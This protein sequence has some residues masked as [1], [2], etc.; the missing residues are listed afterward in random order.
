M[1]TAVKLSPATAPPRQGLGKKPATRRQAPAN[2]LAG[3]KV[4]WAPTA[5][6]AGRAAPASAGRACGLLPAWLLLRLLLR[7]PRLL[8]CRCALR[9][10][11]RESHAANRLRAKQRSAAQP[12]VTL[13]LAAL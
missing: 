4:F 5:R 13:Q 2:Q 10:A 7:L 9:P 11:P 3:K 12:A 6:A 1:N 8:S